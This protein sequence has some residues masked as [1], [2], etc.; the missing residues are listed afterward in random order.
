MASGC[1]LRALPCLEYVF[2]V[3]SWGGVFQGQCRGE[4]YGVWLIVV[5]RHIPV[6]PSYR[7]CCPFLGWYGE[8]GVDDL[9]V[10]PNPPRLC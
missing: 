3:R 8:L 7:S 5:K 2:R 6:R 9:V 4:E 1:T 10:P